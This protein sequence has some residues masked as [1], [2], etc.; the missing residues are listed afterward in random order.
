MSDVTIVF[1][2]LESLLL[3]GCALAFGWGMHRN[4]GLEMFVPPMVL[5]LGTVFL[6][7]SWLVTVVV[8]DYVHPS[9]G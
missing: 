4:W 3:I 1:G 2:L 7:V 5:F 8:H 6:A 9:F